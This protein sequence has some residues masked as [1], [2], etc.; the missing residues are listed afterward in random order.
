MKAIGINMC[1]IVEQ[2]IEKFI[3]ADWYTLTIAAVT[4]FVSALAGAGFGAWLAFKNDKKLE[5]D[6]TKKEELNCIFSYYGYLISL[7]HG[8]NTTAKSLDDSLMDYHIENNLSKLQNAK[9]NWG[10]L[11]FIMNNSDKLVEKT[12]TL[13]KDIDVCIEK[14]NLYSEVAGE[15]EKSIA[16]RIIAMR[17]FT[18]VYIGI[19]AMLCSYDNYAKRYYDKSL[20]NQEFK[21]DIKK[22]KKL[23]EKLVDNISKINHS[24]WDVDAYLNRIKEKED[25][26]LQF[27]Q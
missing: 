2:I 5:E 8:Y 19:I 21:E 4:S 3:S 20:I 9:C 22:A 17:I 26:F 6:K 13:E 15:G 14:S 25:W 18:E 11:N 23:S 1:I 16:P 12:F 10:C 27:N 24:P 7:F